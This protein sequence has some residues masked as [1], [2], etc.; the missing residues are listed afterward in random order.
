[1][2]NAAR[3]TVALALVAL[4]L[5][6]VPAAS[7]AAECPIVLQGH[8]TCL[9]EPPVNVPQTDP[10]FNFDAGSWVRIQADGC[11][12]THGSGLSWFRY[13]DP[14]SP[15]D[16]HFG[17]A[18]VLS[19]VGGPPTITLTALRDISPALRFRVTTPS[20][21]RLA[22]KDDAYDQNGYDAHDNGPGNQ[23]LSTATQYGGPA[24][25]LLTV[26]P[27]AAPTVQAGQ[28][29]A[30]V[31]GKVTFQAFPNDVDHD[32][33]SYSYLLDGV[34]LAGPVTAP[35]FDWTSAGDGPHTLQ[36]RVDDPYGMS[37]TSEPRTFVVDNASPAVT[38][39][40]GP[41]NQTFGPHTS[42]TWT[43]TANDGAG[44]GI[45]GVQCRVDGAAVPCSAAA[46]HT[47][48]DLAAGSHTFSV[49]ATDKLGHVS[50]VESRTITID[51]GAPD[52]AITG[53]PDE[54]S[55]GTGT[56]V[57]FLFSASKAGS[58][59][60]CQAYLASLPPLLPAF[61]PCS[62]GSAHVLRALAP[63]A[64]VFEVR[65]VDA[66]GNAD[67]TPAVRHF[68]V[69]LPP[70]PPPPPPPPTIPATVVFAYASSTH[71]TR[72][73]VKHIPAGSTVRVT[74]KGRGCPRTF[75]KKRARGTLSLA[76]LIRHPLKPGLRM[77]IVVSKPGF[78]SATKVLRIRA[79]KPPTVD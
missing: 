18:G 25:V 23:C 48:N 39:T 69:V 17:S 13:V 38:I 45:Q 52:T 2:G 66:L 19:R 56:T 50:A 46:S 53:G 73:V 12:Q 33:I 74:C 57:Q 76:R 60:E 29:P 72:L 6:A 37:G 21:L 40:G 27:D 55:T 7:R 30:F 3:L 9:F 14:S 51:A 47:V 43:F 41:A 58:R 4:T 28:L 44:S 59:F 65:A 36:I 24:Y 49:Q 54:G 78:R 77:T 5:A 31:A 61:A 67:L 70:P 62:D 8:Q 71:M 68:T 16:N 32:P 64:Y 75:V 42:Q 10:G 26:D 15:A 34:K 11:V 22:Y 1:M 35:T 79:H 63:A 20:F